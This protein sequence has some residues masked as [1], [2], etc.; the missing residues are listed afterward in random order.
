[1]CFPADFRSSSIWFW[2]PCGH[3]RRVFCGPGMLRA[4]DVFLWRS[5]LWI[6]N[7]GRSYVV[8]PQ[9]KHRPNVWTQDG[10]HSGDV[11]GWGRVHQ[12]RHCKMLDN[13]DRSNVSFPRPVGC[14]GFYFLANTAANVLPAG[15]AAVL[16]SPV[17][18]GNGKTE[19]VHFWYNMGGKTPGKTPLR[20]NSWGWWI[21]ISR[22]VI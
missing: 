18:P 20:A 19:C 6:H 16:V 1:M 7:L 21:F 13:E 22:E 5:A 4:E 12:G 10:P 17:R 2:W 9:W 11:H 8:P 3:R 14:T 15:K